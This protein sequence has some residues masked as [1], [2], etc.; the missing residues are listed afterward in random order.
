MTKRKR[1]WTSSGDELKSADS[2]YLGM[3]SHRFAMAASEWALANGDPESGWEKAHTPLPVGEGNTW[4]WLPHDLHQIHGLL[5]SQDLGRKCFWTSDV[6]RFLEGPQFCVNWFELFDIYT[7]ITGESINLIRANGDRIF[8]H[9]KKSAAK[10]LKMSYSTLLWNLTQHKV[11][12]WTPEYSAHYEPV[13]FEICTGQDRVSHT[14]TNK[15][16]E[17]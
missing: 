5:Q 15:I 1:W 9:S 14:S 16:K 12:H 2:R 4:V 13:I 7:N 10:T 17:K 8:F 6:K 3:R 11:Y